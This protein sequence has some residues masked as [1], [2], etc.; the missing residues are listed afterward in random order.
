MFCPIV[1]TVQLSVES[2]CLYS[3]TYGMSVIVEPE[4][5]QEDFQALVACD[6]NGQVTPAIG[7]CFPLAGAA[8][9]M[10]VVQGRRA[11][12][13]VVIDVPS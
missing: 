2:D 6:G 12:G 3:P 4:A 7:R 10:P 5:N 13:K 11:L 1:C 9:G 8:G